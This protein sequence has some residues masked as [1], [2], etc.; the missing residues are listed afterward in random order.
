M[1]GWFR[2]K[3]R[4][5]EFFSSLYRNKYCYEYLYAK[6]T[7]VFTVQSERPRLYCHFQKIGGLFCKI[8]EAQA[9]RHASCFSR[10]MR[11]AKRR[12]VDFNHSDSDE[13]NTSQ[14]PHEAIQETNLEA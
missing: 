1:F 9:E 10:G 14:L 2:K 8:A 4:I 11:R 12:G 6:I 13:S 7:N 5:L 3:R